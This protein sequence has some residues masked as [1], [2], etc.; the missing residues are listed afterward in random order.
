MG[1][2]LRVGLKLE[3]D[4]HLPKMVAN[5]FNERIKTQQILRLILIIHKRFIVYR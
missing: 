5:H 4:P 1:M 3:N 2:D